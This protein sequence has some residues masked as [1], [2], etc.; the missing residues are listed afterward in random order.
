MDNLSTTVVGLFFMKSGV[1]GRLSEGG[2]DDIHQL[3]SDQYLEVRIEPAPV[4]GNNLAPVDGHYTE[5]HNYRSACART[6]LAASRRSALVVQKIYPGGSG[7]ASSIARQLAPSPMVV[8]PI[9]G[10]DALDAAI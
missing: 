7:I 3:H 9:G 5:T 6:G 10:E 4:K 1:A 2:H 8:F